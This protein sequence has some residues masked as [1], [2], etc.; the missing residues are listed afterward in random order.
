MPD[1]SFVLDVPYDQDWE[2]IQ[3]ILMQGAEVEVLA[4]DGLRAKVLKAIKSMA[5]VC[6]GAN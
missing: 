2:L 1:G 4:P 3:N 5:S 6:Q